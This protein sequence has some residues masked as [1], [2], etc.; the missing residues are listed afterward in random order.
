[1]SYSVNIDFD[2]VWVD[3]LLPAISCC[4]L[5]AIF[6][7]FIAFFLSLC[8]FF[9]FS[10]SSII[11]FIAISSF[12]LHFFSSYSTIAGFSLTSLN[13]PVF[14][15]TFE[16]ISWIALSF[17]ACFLASKIFLYSSSNLIIYWVALRSYSDLSWFFT[18]STYLTFFSYRASLSRLLFFKSAKEMS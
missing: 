7:S 4:T 13:L 15:F 2:E 10:S 16:N 8:W 3:N 14:S 1:M 18:S 17:S 5:F 9:Y 12:Y 11:I 6:Y